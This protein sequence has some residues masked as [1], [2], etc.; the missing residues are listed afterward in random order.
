MLEKR[1]L[2]DADEAL[3][4]EPSE[5]K[6]VVEDMVDARLVESAL[7]EKRRHPH[8]RDLLERLPQ[9]DVRVEKGEEERIEDSAGFRHR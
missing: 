4:S 1:A 9:A 7:I 8:V 3:S 5:G 2:G 6:E